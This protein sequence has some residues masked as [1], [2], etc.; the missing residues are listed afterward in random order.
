[1]R[2]NRP[3]ESGGWST[4][5]RA[6][7]PRTGKKPGRSIRATDDEWRLIKQFAAIVKE[8]PKVAEEM[9]KENKNHASNEANKENRVPSGR[10]ISKVL[11]SMRTSFSEIK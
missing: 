3:L 2:G 9:L 11:D 8:S 4:A 5:G 10:T 1:M 7:R 6:G